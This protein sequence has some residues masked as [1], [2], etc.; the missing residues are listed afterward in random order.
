MHGRRND[1]PLLSPQIASLPAPVEDGTPSGTA[2]PVVRAARRIMF[3]ALPLAALGLV[4]GLDALSDSAE[5]GSLL[6]LGLLDEP[7]HFATVWLFLA[8]FLPV[9]Y[10]TI[11]L[12]ALVGSVAIDVDHVPLYLWHV[13][14]ADAD[15]RP[16]THSLATVVVLAVA[17]AVGS[18]RFRSPLLGLALGAVLHFFRDL[19][20]GPGVP[21]L[22]PL[23]TANATL[24]HA[25]Y[26][27]VLTAVAVAAVARRSLTTPLGM[28]RGI[29]PPSRRRTP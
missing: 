1:D 6:L 24:P 29:R 17:A 25:T 28:D 26:L 14:A 4:A 22:W 23:T 27:L 20:E 7:A 15:S 11:Y 19:A 5:T 10:R 21:L 2:P 18:P 13:L 16:V 3:A 12:W 9:Q 8:A